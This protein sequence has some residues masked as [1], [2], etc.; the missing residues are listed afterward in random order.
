MTTSLSKTAEVIGRRPKPLTDVRAKLRRARQ[1]LLEVKAYAIDQHKPGVSRRP[2]T[3]NPS[4]PTTGGHWTIPF[5]IDESLALVV[6]EAIQSLRSALDYM[7]HD[8]AWADSKVS[9]RRMQF[10][11]C[12]NPREF[13]S[14][15]AK[16][17]K[18]MKP[19][20][21]AMV[22]A[23]QPYNGCDWTRLIRDYSNLEKHAHSIAVSWSGRL[24]FGISMTVKPDQD[25][26][27]LVAEHPADVWTVL[28]AATTCLTASH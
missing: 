2:G 27:R 11:I 19:A 1:K 8:L 13:R 15:Q 3:A 4:D 21:I 16:A 26:G 5:P 25:T 20:H 6:G 10:L 28:K 18:G 22:E 17:L 7:I 23:V 12:D 9:T 24:Q 14:K